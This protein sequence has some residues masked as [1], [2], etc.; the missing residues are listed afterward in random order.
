[1]PLFASMPI[2]VKLALLILSIALAVSVVTD[3]RRRLILN[4]VTG[5]ALL[6]ILALSFWG[7]GWDEVLNSLLGVAVCALPFALAAL[8]GWMGLG[9][10]KL[11][12]VVGAAFGWPLGLTA[13]FGVVIAGGVQAVVWLVAAR[14]RGAE[15]P[16]HVP[17]AVA[18]AAGTGG[19]FL[20]GGLV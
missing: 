16:R 18:I 15:R 12:A 5:P 9:D 19:A 8:P 7:G 11:M 20:L 4:L 6:A 17:Y 2:P 13:L 14:L 1:M 3:L 10:A